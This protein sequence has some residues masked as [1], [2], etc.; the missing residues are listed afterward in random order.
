[1]VTTDSYNL[2]KQKLFGVSITFYESKGD[3]RPN[4]RTACQKKL[5]VQWIF[6][7]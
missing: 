5:D 3:M 7:L 6:I 2:H 4:L 1:M